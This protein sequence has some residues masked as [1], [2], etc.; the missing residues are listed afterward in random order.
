MWRRLLSMYTILNICAVLTISWMPEPIKDIIRASTLLILIV[1]ITI[2]TSGKARIIYEEL[3]DSFAPNNDIHPDIKFR[4]T[5]VA[6]FLLHVVPVLV[7]GLPV[8]SH[9]MLIAYMIL[10]MWYVPVREHISEIYSK[11]VPADTA[12][13]YAGIVTAGSMLVLKM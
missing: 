11:S 10:L 5:L 8:L 12:I 1:M 13:L 3:F 7:I 2:W 9:S 4:I 6:D